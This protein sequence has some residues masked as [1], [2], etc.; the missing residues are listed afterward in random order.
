MTRPALASVPAVP[1]PPR[2]PSPRIAPSSGVLTVS[3]LLPPTLQERAEA[4]L[5]Q[6]QETLELGLGP[7]AAWDPVRRPRLRLVAR[8][9]ADLDRVAA[10]FAQILVEVLTGDRGPHQLLHWT[11]EE[12]YLVLQRRAAALQRAVSNAAP[13]RRLSAQVRSVHLTRPQPDAAELGIHVR[14]GARSRAIAARI[15]LGPDGRWRC[16]ALELG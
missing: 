7:G 4:P 15:E 3:R 2:R 14:H 6:V 13:T 5:A 16:C 9:G 11:T 1:A 8:D 12:I 10:R